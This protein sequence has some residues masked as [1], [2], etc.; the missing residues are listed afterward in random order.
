[1]HVLQSILYTP[2]TFAK[3]FGII[4]YNYFPPL[5]GLFLFLNE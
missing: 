2:H 5:N 1:M 3:R 4:P